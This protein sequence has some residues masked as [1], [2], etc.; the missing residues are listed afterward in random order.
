MI[1]TEKVTLTLP[2]DLMVAVRSM[3]P[4]RRQSQFIAEALRSYIAEQQRQSLRA[5]LIAG[6]QTNAEADVAIAGE[7]ATV[8]DEAW[9]TIAP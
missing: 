9:Q 3:A 7:W 4:A 6:Y 2:A 8:E 1:A 5:R